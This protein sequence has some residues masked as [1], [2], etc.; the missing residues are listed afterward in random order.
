MLMKDSFPFR[1]P[2]FDLV[3]P[4]FFSGLSSLSPRVA[5]QTHPALSRGDFSQGTLG[6]A[7][8]RII[9]YRKR[10]KS[11]LLVSFRGSSL[12][13]L[14]RKILKAQYRSEELKTLS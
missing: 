14:K 8:Q 7:P 1:P 13:E 4:S 9:N 12:V 11:F 10:Q 5:S 3:I 2:A 6:H